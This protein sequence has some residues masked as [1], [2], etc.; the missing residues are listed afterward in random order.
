MKIEYMSDEYLMNMVEAIEAHDMVSAP[1]D[2][3][4][5]VLARL[6]LAEEEANGE[7]RAEVA[8]AVNPIT[9]ARI[10]GEQRMEASESDNPMTDARIDGEQRTEASESYNPITDARVDGKQRA[11]DWAQ[12]TAPTSLTAPRRKR[13]FRIYCFK[14]IG[15]SAAA[16]LI[17][18]SL[19]VLSPEKAPTPTK[20]EVLG[21]STATD[22]TVNTNVLGNIINEI[23]TSA[24]LIEGQT[25]AQAGEPTGGQPDELTREHTSAQAGEPKMGQTDAQPGGSDEN[26]TDESG[27]S[28][29]GF[30]RNLDR[31]VLRKLG[32]SRNIGDYF[33]GVD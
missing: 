16:I 33:N 12:Q 1:P 24:G 31:G 9:D 21:A 22:S 11:D 6:G 27:K 28:N 23:V 14:V 15:A 3:Q 4:S 7:Q 13:E 20:Q 10:D 29:E 25:G 30:Y 18:L 19:P 5:E 17:A 2:L 8:E 26:V 32:S